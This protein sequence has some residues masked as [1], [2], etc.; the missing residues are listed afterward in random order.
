LKT[1]FRQQ[2]ED[3]CKTTI[4]TTSW[5]D[6]N[7]ADLRLAELLH[8]RGINATFYIPIKYSE[9]TLSENEVK[10]L[11]SRFE[12]GAHGFTH[13]LLSRL[14]SD[15][16]VEEIGACKTT[17]EDITSREV[18]MFCYPCGRYDNRVVRMLRAF[19]YRGG[20]TTRMLGM[21]PQ[22]DSFEMPTTVQAFP[23][24]PLAYLKNLAKGGKFEYFK[25]FMAQRARLGNWVELSK[26][27]FDVALQDGGVWHLYGHSWEIDRLRLWDDLREVLDY[28]SRRKGVYYMTNGELVAAHEVT[29]TNGL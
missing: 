29:S 24:A 9:Q 12:V 5:D 14:T 13:K 10:G 11:A 22:F 18:R 16:L 4:V 17:L 28:I 23:H 15:E 2:P 7:S 27:L 3:R 21:Q 26:S 19:G 8:S 25:T 1:T 6:G 20:R